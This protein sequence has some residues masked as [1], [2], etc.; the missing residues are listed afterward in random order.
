VTGR[1]FPSFPMVTRLTG[2][3]RPFTCRPRFEGVSPFAKRG[4]FIHGPPKEGR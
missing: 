2:G 4:R 3:L 1:A